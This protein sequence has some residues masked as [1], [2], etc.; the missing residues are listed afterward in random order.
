[1]TGTHMGDWP[2]TPYP[3]RRPDVSVLVDPAGR[4]HSVASDPSGPGRWRTEHG[5]LDDHL[6]AEGAAP[7]AERVPVLAYGSNASPGKIAQMSHPDEA[8]LPLPAVLLRARAH[9]LAAAWAD[10]RRARDGAVPATLVA[11]PG[12]VEWMAVLMVAADQWP[13]L[14]RVEGRGARP[15]SRYRL[16]RVTAGTVELVDGTV[17]D[18]VW[19]YV[20]SAPSRRPAVGPDGRAVLMADAPAPLPAGESGTTARVESSG[21][22]AAAKRLGDWWPDDAVPEP[23]PRAR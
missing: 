19:A 2:A 7:L 4:V 3:G 14:D 9:G 11:S 21:A 23:V 15:E 22:D 1:M 12:R 13:A 8:G 18:P 17:L 10:G 6:A 20:G 16:M 5:D